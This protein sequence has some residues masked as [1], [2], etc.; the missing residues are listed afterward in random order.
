VL[1][2]ELHGFLEYRLAV[3]VQ[4]GDGL[5]EIPGAFVVIGSQHASAA[6]GIAG[7][8]VSGAVQASPQYAGRFEDRNISAGQVAVADHEGGGGKR[9]DATTHQI[10][11]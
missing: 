5:V 7:G 8:S 4:R 10:G 11:L 3:V 2:I 9:S 6:H 1:L